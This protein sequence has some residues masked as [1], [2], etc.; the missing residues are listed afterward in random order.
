MMPVLI[1][2]PMAEGSANLPLVTE[3]IEEPAQP[4]TML[5]GHL[6]CWRCTSRNGLR[7]HRVGIVDH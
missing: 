7:E 3:W 4:P 6:G 1:W 2:R 5:T